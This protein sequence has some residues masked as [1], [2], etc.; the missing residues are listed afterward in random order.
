MGVAWLQLASFFVSL[1]EVPL[2]STVVVVFAVYEKTI[3]VQ[4]LLVNTR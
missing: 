4:C 2:R 1:L 3:L